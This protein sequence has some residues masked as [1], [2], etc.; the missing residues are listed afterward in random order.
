M[1]GLSVP[2]SNTIVFGSKIVCTYVWMY[3]AFGQ[4]RKPTQKENSIIIDNNVK[5]FRLNQ[6]TN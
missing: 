3:V 5:Y 2:T 4:K 6:H 1:Y